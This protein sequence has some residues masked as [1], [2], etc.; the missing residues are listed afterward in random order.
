MDRQVD[1][2]KALGMASERPLRDRDEVAE[3]REQFA[4]TTRERDE[5]RESSGILGRL[6]NNAVSYA[7]KLEKERDTLRDQL[8]TVQS[9]LTD[10]MDTAEALYK[11]VPVAHERGQLS[12]NGKRKPSEMVKEYLAELHA[13]SAAMFRLV[14]KYAMELRG[15]HDPEHFQTESQRSIS[16]ELYLVRKVLDGTAGRELLDQLKRKD[17][18]IAD[19]ER[20]LAEHKRDAELCR[21]LR[22][23]LQL[24]KGRAGIYSHRSTHIS[25]PTSDGANAIRLIL[26]AIRDGG[27]K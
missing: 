21:G 22:A 4:T 3:L 15:E 8:A 19:L 18:R 17:E 6:N 13:E 24:C 20:Q 16:Y 27:A 12:E 26:I 2:N 1:I 10:W 9:Q 14:E 11:A 7:E 5:L 25:P 23:M